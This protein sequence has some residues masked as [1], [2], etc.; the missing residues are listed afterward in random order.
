M[1]DNKMQNV[2]GTVHIYRPKKAKPH[3]HPEWFI[4]PDKWFLTEADRDEWIKQNAG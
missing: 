2:T 3:P 4:D 1:P